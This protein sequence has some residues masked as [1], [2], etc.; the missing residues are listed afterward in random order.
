MITQEDIENEIAK[1]EDFFKQIPQELKA[2]AADHFIFEIALWGG[3]SH[4]EI[5]GLFTEALHRYREIMQEAMEEEDE[6]E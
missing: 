5:L 6:D 2:E 1:V 4:Y 3:S